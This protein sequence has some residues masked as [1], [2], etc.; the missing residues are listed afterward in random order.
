MPFQLKANM[1]LAPI[2]RRNDVL[3]MTAEQ[4]EEFIQKIDD[5]VAVEDKVCIFFFLFF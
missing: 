5:L 1:F 2:C 4:K 3:N